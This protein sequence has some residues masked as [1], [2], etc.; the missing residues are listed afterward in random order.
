[1]S[2]A[3]QAALEYWRAS[4][5]RTRERLRSLVEHFANINGQSADIDH[6]YATAVA[7]VRDWEWKK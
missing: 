4:G 3:A 2:V 1:M 6:L 5:E 7:A